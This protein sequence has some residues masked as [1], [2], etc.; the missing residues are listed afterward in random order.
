MRFQFQLAPLAYNKG[1]RHVT[2][3]AI[4]DADLAEL[5]RCNR[6]NIAALEEI[7]GVDV[8]GNALAPAG[9]GAKSAELRAAGVGRR[10]LPVSKPELKAR[11]VSA[12]ETKV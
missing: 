7:I 5:E 2:G 6:L 1:F 4:K 11:L 9:R 8:E 12:L 10:R 3:A